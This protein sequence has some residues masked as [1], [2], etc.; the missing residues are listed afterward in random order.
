MTTEL[1]CPRDET[2]LQPGREHDIEV[3]RCP[4]CGGAWYADEELELLESTVADD[5]HR[6]GM[7]DYAKRPSELKCP[8]CGEPMRAFNYRAYNLELDAC[9]HEHGFWLDKGEADHVRQV[10]R[11]RVRGLERAAGAERDWRRT[12]RGESGIM[13]QLRNLFRRR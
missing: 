8:A 2:P 4:Q 10:M 13:D 12:V 3:D 9:S 5:H 6:A 11:D 1:R 7:V